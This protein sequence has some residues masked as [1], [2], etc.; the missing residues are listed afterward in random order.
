MYG[1]LNL[2]VGGAYDLPLTNKTP[3]ARWP[4]ATPT[5]PLQ[6][7]TPSCKQMCY[8]SPLLAFEKQAAMWQ[9]D[10]WREG[11]KGTTGLLKLGIA[12]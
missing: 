11:H 8:L 1:S 6:Y 3:V 5:I 2:S 4:G 12:Q 9:E 7:M 10:L